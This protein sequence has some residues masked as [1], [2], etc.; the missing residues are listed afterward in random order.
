MRD[1]SPSRWPRSPPAGRPARDPTGKGCT[2][3]PT[4][5]T[6]GQSSTAEGR[7]ASSPASAPA[8]A[9]TGGWGSRSVFFGFAFP[10]VE[11]VKFVERPD[12]AVDRR[13]GTLRQRWR[14]VVGEHAVAFGVADDE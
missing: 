1:S 14:V 10:A 6:R 2:R 3:P 5:G 13:H 9:G 8:S 12:D 4:G 7:P 11:A